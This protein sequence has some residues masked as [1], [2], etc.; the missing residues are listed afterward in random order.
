MELET[1]MDVAMQF[2]QEECECLDPALWNL[3]RDVMQE[4]YRNLDFLGL[5]IYKLSLT[6]FLEQMKKVAALLPTT[7]KGLKVPVAQHPHQH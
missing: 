3:Y 2:S 6:T 7:Q 1:I 5:S 4:N